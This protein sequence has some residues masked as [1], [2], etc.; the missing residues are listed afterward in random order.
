MKDPKDELRARRK[1]EK[2]SGS[3]CANSSYLSV[4]TGN[5]VS[6]TAA[7]TWLASCC[8]MPSLFQVRH[9]EQSKEN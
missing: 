4:A 9:K 6:L 7:A 8:H 1:R 2:G 3:W 5:Q